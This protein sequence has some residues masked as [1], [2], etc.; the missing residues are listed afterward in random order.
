MP[1]IRE[2]VFVFILAVIAGAVIRL[3][4]QCITCFRG[5]VKHSALAVAAEDLLYWVGTAIYVFVQIYHTSDGSIRWYFILGSVAGAVFSS[6]LLKK[7]R[8]KQKK[9]YTEKQKKSSEKLAK[10]TEER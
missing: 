5:I 6:F 9:I 4:Y 2:E 3:S 10:K 7:I 8:K 1:Q